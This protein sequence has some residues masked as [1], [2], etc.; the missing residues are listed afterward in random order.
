[1]NI[2]PQEEDVFVQMEKKHVIYRVIQELLNNAFKY[3]DANKIQLELK[4]E[5]QRFI[6]LY[7]DDGKGFDAKK[8]KKGV[9][10]DSMRSRIRFHKGEISIQTAPGKGVKI[11]IQ[12]P[13]NLT[14]TKQNLINTQTIEK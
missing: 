2:Y 14:D 13:L 5:Q 1:L 12:M 9:G 4:I 10:L 11:N 7:Q 6:M 8:I 3:A